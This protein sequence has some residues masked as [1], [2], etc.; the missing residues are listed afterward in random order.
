MST[1]H[2]IVVAADPKVGEE[3]IG[4]AFN[5]LAFAHELKQ[6]NRDVQITFVGTGTRWIGALTTPDHP[7]TGLFEQVKDK[8]LGISCGCSDVFGAREDADSSPFPVLTDNAIPGTSGL[9]S[10]AHWSSEGYQIV[11]F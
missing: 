11:V 1:K 9:V 2:L 4:R 6:Q 5:A 8:V 10:L 7:L 3:S